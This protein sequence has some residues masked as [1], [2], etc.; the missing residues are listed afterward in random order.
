VSWGC[1][2]EA[3]VRAVQVNGRAE[4]QVC[5]L[6]ILLSNSCSREIRTCL[7]SPPLSPP[8]SPPSPRMP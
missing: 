6:L 7:L 4:Q 2:K 3:S 8:A 5:V 1:V